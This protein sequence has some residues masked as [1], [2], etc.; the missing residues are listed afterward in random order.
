MKRL[1]LGLVICL[2]FIYLLLAFKDPFNTRSLVPNLEPYPDTLYYATPAWNFVNGIGFSMKSSFLEVKQQV[3]PLYSIYLIPFFTV[4]KDVR[5]YYFGNLL[6]GFGSLVFFL[7]SCYKLFRNHS[8]VFLLGFLYITNFYVY[9]LPTLLMAENPTLFLVNFGTY[10]LLSKPTKP[11]L[12]LAGLLGDTLW[13]TKLS[14]G[15]IGLLFYIFYWLKIRKVKIDR[16]AFLVTSVISVSLFIGYLTMSGLLINHKNE[17]SFNPAYF[18]NNLR[19]Y[20]RLIF[21]E[22]GRYLWFTYKFTTIFISI[23][24]MLGLIFALSSRRHRI[25][26]SGF[27]I[28]SI[29]VI[30]PASFFEVQ[31]VRFILFIFPTLLF[32]I[33]Y[34]FSYFQK[35]LPKVFFISLLGIVLLTYLFLPLLNQKENE[36][37][38]ITFKKQ[39]GLNLRHSESPWN[40]S[41][42]KNFNDYFKGKSENTYLGTVLPV[43][44]VD[45]FKNDNYQYLAITSNQ[46]FFEHEKNLSKKYADLLRTG[47]RVYVT[48][49]YLNNLAIWKKDYVNLTQA[50]H[51]KLVKEGCLGSC[52]IYQLSLQN[53]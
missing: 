30:V 38:I 39:I 35:K 15:L 20:I 23:L 53:E 29:L 51:T 34:L 6:L 45:Y 22:E 41:A 47:N 52:N 1:W 10:I 24:S 43:F 44:Y 14:N 32:A 25:Y 18:V 31:D 36:I 46:D 21:G 48:N 33:G 40:Y 7:L 4:F 26:G 42:I 11:K 12:M 16:K 5:S 50:F 19:Y 13:F 9:N 49:A 2:P 28:F 3:A 17:S 8:L 37:P 27:L